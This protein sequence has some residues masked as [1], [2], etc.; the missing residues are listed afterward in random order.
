M[1]TY[2]DTVKKSYADVPLTDEG[3]DTSAFLEATEGLVKL[4][5]LLGSSAFA[6]VQNDMR[7]NVKKIRDRLLASPMESNTLERLVANEGKPGE[8]KRVATEGLMWL[9]RGLDFTAQALRRSQ[10]DKSE[11]L[12]VS[13]TKAYE[14]TLRKY[15]NFV[16]KGA[17]GLAMKACPWRKDFY[18][19][20]GSPPE[21]VESELEAWLNALEKIVSQLQGFYAQGNY[22]KGL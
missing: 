21:R 4:F 16:V 22:D 5:D 11:E 9:L 1:T 18:E 12:T 20:L 14:G 2:F 13:F 3:V 19:K 10:T 15:H 7:G 6:I 8:K 17:F